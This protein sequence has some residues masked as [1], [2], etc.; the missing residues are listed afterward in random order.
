M[1]DAPHALVDLAIISY[2]ALCPILEVHLRQLGLEMHIQL[3]DVMQF[4]GLPAYCG[5]AIAPVMRSNTDQWS[6]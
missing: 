1:V 3:L 5:I 2:G 6:L 4:D